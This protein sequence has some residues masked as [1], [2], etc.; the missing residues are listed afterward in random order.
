MN[1][2]IS[3]W[4]STKTYHTEKNV[5]LCLILDLK[6][7]LFYVIKGEISDLWEYVVKTKNY[8]KVL[9]YVNK[10]NIK[11]NL[12][13]FFSELENQGI[14][15]TDI[16]F[17]Q[18]KNKYLNNKI[19]FHSKNYPYFQRLFRKFIINNNYWN[20]LQL[21]V[22]YKCNLNCR[23]CYNPKNMNKYEIKLSDVKKIIDE[24][25]ALGV[26]YVVISGGECTIN[27]DFL[28]IV[29]YIR[30]NYL[31]LV[32][33][34]NGQ[35]L[36]DNPKL[37][38]EIV[39]LYP[40][41]QLSLYS[42]DENIHDYITRVK[43][44]YYKTKF[45]I[46]KLREYG[47]SVTISCFQMI[48][49]EGH[50]KKVKEFADSIGAD[51]ITDF[52]FINNVDNNNYCVKLSNEGIKKYYQDKIL[53]DG[54]N[55]IN[56]NINNDNFK[57]GT[58][59]SA[60]TDR[61]CISPNLDITPCNYFNYILGNYNNKTLLEI[62]N[63]IIPKFKKTYIRKNLKNCFKYDYCKY[64]DY[65]SVFATEGFMKKSKILCES[66]QEYKK[67]LKTI[68]EIQNTKVL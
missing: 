2:Y 21:V 23:H 37:F 14:I 45:I 59:C 6:K 7:D 60:G 38:N 51:F 27:N 13:D 22:S 41:F 42:M 68:Q 29:E 17:N 3:D 12:Y 33:L 26:W 63:E 57:N 49:N 9:D 34:T 64:C 11:V 50:Y 5:S 20:L 10:T 16:Q 36:Y 61:I 1:F 44:S 56:K 52:T 19:S 58:I 55:I 4:I 47:L 65:C 53:S 18:S 43:G 25:K 30:K 8:N 39:K 32:I 24:V 48:Y 54:L 31:N 35:E 28:E 66:S 67:A 62:K 15:K 46:N 40:T